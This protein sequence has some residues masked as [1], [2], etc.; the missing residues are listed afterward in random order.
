VKLLLSERVNLNKTNKNNESP[1]YI[2]CFTGNIELVKLLLNEKR[3][4]IWKKTNQEK[5]A[6]DIAKTNNHSE[7][8]KLIQEV[9]TG[10]FTKQLIIHH[11]KIIKKQIEQRHR[12]YLDTF[13]NTPFLCIESETINKQ[14][15][16]VLNKL[17][18]KNKNIKG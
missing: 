3:I 6:F 7:I 10:N 12:E 11:N 14:D 8:M 1:F 17:L 2:A 5:T 4:S 9:D 16:L 15:F 18:K 13:Q